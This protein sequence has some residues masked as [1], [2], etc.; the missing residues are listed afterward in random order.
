[1]LIMHHPAG[2]APLPFPKPCFLI[3]MDNLAKSFESPYAV[4]RKNFI[5]WVISNI[6]A[7]AVSSTPKD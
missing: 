6:A 3:S 4:Q 7:T 1:M 5:S 2:D